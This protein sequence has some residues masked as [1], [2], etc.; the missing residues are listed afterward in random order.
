MYCHLTGKPAESTVKPVIIRIFEPAL[1][2][3]KD[4]DSR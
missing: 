4:V 2:K 1:I 3:A